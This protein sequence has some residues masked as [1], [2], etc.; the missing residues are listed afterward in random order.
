MP[1]EMDLVSRNPVLFCPSSSCPPSGRV[2][3]HLGESTGPDSK[4]SDFEKEAINSTDKNKCGCVT[5]KLCLAGGLSFSR[6]LCTRI[7][8]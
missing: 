5:L 8:L 4:Y 7:V 1:R 2:G 3:S 6:S